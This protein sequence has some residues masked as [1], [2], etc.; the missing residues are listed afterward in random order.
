MSIPPVTSL[1]QIASAYAAMG[2]SG[3]AA[4]GASASASSAGGDFS[5]MVGNAARSALQTVREAETTTAR[6][7]AGRTDVQSVVQAMSNAE[8][9]VQ[10]VVAVRD[11]VV[12]A[13][14]D[15]MR[16]AV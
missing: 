2:G 14:D 7:V 8:I 3:S 6:G 1:S 10:A 12:G 4:S 13:Y 9:T 16:M 11:K 15:V 5:D